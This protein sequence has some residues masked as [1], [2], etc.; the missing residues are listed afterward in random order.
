MEIRKAAYVTTAVRRDQYPEEG[1]PEIAFVGRSN[2]GKS[3]LINLLTRNKKLA[4]TSGSPGKTRTINFFLINDE[5]LFADLPGYG[6]AKVGMETKATWGKMMENYLIGREVLRG[7]IQLIDIRHK[8]S[9]QDQEMME[10]LRYYD[11]PVVIA[12][13]KS[14]KISYGQQARHIRQIRESLDFHGPIVPCSTL[15]KKGIAELTQEMQNLID[16]P[17]QGADGDEGGME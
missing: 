7:V 10:F 17:Q 5:F 11:I 14:D 4:R 8:P 9:V 6:Y 2:V 12:A 13:T 15:N 1:L 16:F 3:S